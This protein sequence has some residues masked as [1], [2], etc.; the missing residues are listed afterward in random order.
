MERRG[1]K[2][3]FHSSAVTT[4]GFSEILVTVSYLE[5]WF[6]SKDWWL[7]LKAKITYNSPWLIEKNWEVHCS[8]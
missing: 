5:T 4:Q 6:T 7:A 3:N 1:C 8:L 2:G